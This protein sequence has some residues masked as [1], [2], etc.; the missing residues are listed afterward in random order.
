MQ[1]INLQQFIEKYTNSNTLYIS[2]HFFCLDDTTQLHFFYNP[3]QYWTTVDKKDIE[4]YVIENLA[5][6]CAVLKNVR[7]VEDSGRKPQNYTKI[8]AFN[9]ETPTIGNHYSKMGNQIFT[10]N[11]KII[12]RD[13]YYHIDHT[14]L[15]KDIKCFDEADL[16]AVLDYSVISKTFIK[17]K[18][19]FELSC[20]KK[21]S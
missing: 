4:Q 16:M 7:I 15:S 14:F 21:P 3:K 8:K 11:S 6:E 19:V 9:L 18:S 5:K 17:I 13:N 2:D 20:F 10:L 1:P 12:I